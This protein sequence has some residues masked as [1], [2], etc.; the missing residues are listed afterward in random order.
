MGKVITR[1][2]KLGVFDIKDTVEDLKFLKSNIKTASEDIIEKLVS[3]G[4][5]EASITN[6]S[7]PQSGIE[8]SVV[9]QRITENRNKGYVA[10]VGRNAVYD[11]FGTGEEGA[12]RPHPKKDKASRP[13]NPYNS[14]PHIFYNQFAGVYQWRYRPMAGKP[15]FTETGLTQGIPAGK[16]I[17][18]ADMRVRKIK[19][20][21]IKE[22]LNES[23]QFFEKKEK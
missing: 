4:Y 6:A 2:M 3:A 8:P 19:N 12:R 15:Y 18:N 5:E 20:D 14:G 23:I 22:T 9:I 17:Y 11:V 7:A 1:H 10:L 13:L 21:V 16:Q